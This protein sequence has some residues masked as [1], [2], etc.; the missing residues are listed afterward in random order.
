MNNNFAPLVALF[1]YKS[2]RKWNWYKALWRQRRD[3]NF[4]HIFVIILSYKLNIF[5]FSSI[6]VSRPVD[7]EDKIFH[8]K[9]AIKIFWQLL[10][11]I[12][13]IEKFHSILYLIHK[14]SIHFLHQSHQKVRTPKKYFYLL[15]CNE[16]NFFSLCAIKW[17]WTKYQ[18][19][20]C[21]GIIIL[22]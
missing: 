9:E 1:V 20:Y 4:W 2:R 21:H 13:R 22:T 8:K 14:K 11:D 15:V 7:D 12:F 18:F 17:F 6:A 19:S 5:H 10:Q 16:R 3:R